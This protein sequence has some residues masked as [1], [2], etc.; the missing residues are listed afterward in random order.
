MLLN[1]HREKAQ[2]IKLPRQPH[3]PDMDQLRAIY[4]DTMRSPGRTT[5]VPFGQS[6]LLTITRK[7]GEPMCTFTLTTWCG[8]QGTE[9]WSH[10]SN[11]P[12]WIAQQI[13]EFFPKYQ[14]YRREIRN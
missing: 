13:A 4:N 9:E 12:R 14:H 7:I 2:F 5:E 8:L 11:D 1:R 3:P 6:A 10:D